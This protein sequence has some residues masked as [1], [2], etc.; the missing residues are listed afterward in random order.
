MEELEGEVKAIQVWKEGCYRQFITNK[1]EDG[2][3]QQTKWRRVDGGGYKSEG[4]TAGYEMMKRMWGQMSIWKRGVLQ[5][6][7]E[8][9]WGE[10]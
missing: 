6:W 5:V 9:T 7:G 3:T 8:G 10:L 2:F 4:G 1:L